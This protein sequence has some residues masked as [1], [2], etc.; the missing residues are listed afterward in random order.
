MWL[1]CL[2]DAVV[3]MGFKK[4]SSNYTIF[5]LKQVSKV[6]VNIIIIGDDPM[7]IN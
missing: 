2:S 1:S 6:T 4:S 7:N 5:T 3:E